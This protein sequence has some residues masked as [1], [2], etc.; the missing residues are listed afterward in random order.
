[1]ILE[2]HIEGYSFHSVDR[3][4]THGLIHH[5]FP[6]VLKPNGDD[7]NSNQFILQRSSILLL[8]RKRELF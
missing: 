7:S 8:L 3:Q 2:G 6:A 4:E 5:E 1:M